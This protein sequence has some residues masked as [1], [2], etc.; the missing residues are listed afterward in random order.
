MRCNFF[1]SNSSQR[2]RVKTFVP[3]IEAEL[4]FKTQLDNIYK[5]DD[6]SAE[7]SNTYT[8]KELGVALYLAHYFQIASTF[9]GEPAPDA[10]YSLLFEDYGGYA[11][12]IYAGFTSD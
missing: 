5:S 10:A 7:L 6:Q 12:E 9:P 8:I 3:R 11:E 4:S 2:F 1:V